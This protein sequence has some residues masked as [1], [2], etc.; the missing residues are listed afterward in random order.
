MNGKSK[1]GMTVAA[2]VTLLAMASP[3]AFAGVKPQQQAVT[4]KN[5][6][7]Q[8]ANGAN[9][10]AQL[11]DYGNGTPKDPGTVVGQSQANTSS[12]GSLQTAKYRGVTNATQDANGSTNVGQQETGATSASQSQKGNWTLL[13]DQNQHAV[14]TT[15]SVQSANGAIGVAGYN[16]QESANN[17]GLAQSQKLGASF[18]GQQ[19]QSFVNHT[20]SGQ[21]ADGSVDAYQNQENTTNGKQAQSS[22]FSM[23]GQDQRTAVV[24]AGGQSAEG[25]N[26]SVQGQ[27]TSTASA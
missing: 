3:M 12:L 19:S 16:T 10:V 8:S 9:G 7:S 20:L 1:T 15:K 18:L 23:T 24:T 22:F 27:T 2:A 21:R 6:L 13:S 17:T 11:Q 25:A 14:N 26:G 4:Q 5:V